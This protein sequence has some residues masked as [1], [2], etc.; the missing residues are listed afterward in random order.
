MIFYIVPITKK[1]WKNFCEIFFYIA[2]IIIFSPIILFLLVILLL[3]IF[4]GQ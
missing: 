4:G 3:S 2:L 1:A